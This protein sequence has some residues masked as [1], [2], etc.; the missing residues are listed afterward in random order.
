MYF[1]YSVCVCVFVHVIFYFFIF[2]FSLFYGLMVPC[3][4]IQ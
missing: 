4:L 3:G 1:L 2:F